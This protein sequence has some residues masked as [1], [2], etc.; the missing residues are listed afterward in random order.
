MQVPHAAKLAIKG[1]KKGEAWRSAI[2]TR[3]PLPSLPPEY[4][5][6]ERIFRCCASSPRRPTLARLARSRPLPTHAPS[7]VGAHGASR[8]SATARPPSERRRVAHVAAA[9]LERRASRRHPIE[10][11]IF[12]GT[13]PP[14]PPPQHP[15]QM[16]TAPLLAPGETSISQPGQKRGG[17]AA[18]AVEH[19][20]GCSPA[21]RQCDAA[22][23]RGC[24]GAGAR[25]PTVCAGGAC[26]EC[27]RR[28][29][30]GG[31]GF[32]GGKREKELRVILFGRAGQ[33]YN[34]LAHAHWSC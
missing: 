25:A 21:S 23:H 1:D 15:A 22:Q 7:R 6:L 3:P 2:G 8:H 16:H 12:G 10:A 30:E 14:I 29:G 11:A 33:G 4:E 20:R 17:E 18:R 5:R 24:V 13:I 32:V 9:R 27:W 26:V 19:S 34:G 28:C 31:D